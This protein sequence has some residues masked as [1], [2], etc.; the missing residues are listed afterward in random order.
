M[1]TMDAGMLVSVLAEHQVLSALH[2][3]EAVKLKLDVVDE[4]RRRIAG[5]E[6]ENDIRDYIAAN[7]W[8]ISPEWE[9]FQIERR[10]GLLVEDPNPGLRMI[11]TS[12]A[13]SFSESCQARYSKSQCDRRKLFESKATW[14][15][16]IGG[17]ATLRGAG[18]G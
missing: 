7:P 9:T 16:L 6:L 12:R 4:L 14:R 15:S 13:Y 8:L 2:V 18:E 5:R 10:I 11:L 3:A 17:S 1:E